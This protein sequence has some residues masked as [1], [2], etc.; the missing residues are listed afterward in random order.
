M[1]FR[2]H[3]T[4]P[5]D[6][7]GYPKYVA[8][9]KA[10]MEEAY[11]KVRLNSQKA[12]QRN[13]KKLDRAIRNAAS[14][15]LNPGD[16]VLIKNTAPHLGPGKLRSHY[17]DKIHTVV[18]RQGDDMPVYKLQP[19]DGVGRN[20]ILHRNLLMP[21]NYLCHENEDPHH[22]TPLQQQQNKGKQQGMK[23]QETSLQNDPPQGDLSPGED[24]LSSG[25]DD[26][27]LEQYMRIVAN[28]PPQ[29]DTTELIHQSSE[30]DPDLKQN[31]TQ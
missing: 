28:Q 22:P 16:R 29:P 4:Q 31:P 8:D 25:E 6:N 30:G 9:W 19:E 5:P 12:A 27:Y 10:R 23:Q 3:E 2:Q 21:C 13:K 1:V 14:Q 11:T 7:P 17:E 15:S 18:S 24:D 20:R 26:D